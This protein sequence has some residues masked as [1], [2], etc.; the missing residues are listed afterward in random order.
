[1]ASCKPCKKAGLKSEKIAGCRFE[2][3]RVSPRS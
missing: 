3:N 1:M 2:F